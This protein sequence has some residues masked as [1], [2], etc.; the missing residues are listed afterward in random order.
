MKRYLLS[1]LFLVL[2]SAV[3]A[4]E[5]VYTPTPKAPENDAANQMPDAVISWYA[6]T[7]S[8]NLQYQLQVD[9]T[10]LFNSPLKI[11]TTQLLV[12]GYKTR[13]LLFNQ[14]YYW[15]VRAIDGETSAWSEAWSFTVFNTV[16][17]KNP[18]ANAAS[19]DP[20]VSIEWASTITT[21]KKPITGITY[22]NYQIDTDTNFNSPNLLQGTTTP[23]VLKASTVNLL[24]G[25][26]YYWRVRAGHAK[27]NSSY[28][29][30]RNFTII[31]KPTLSTPANNATKVFLDVILKWKEIKGLLAYGY[32]IAKDEAFTNMVESSDIDTNLVG[33]TNLMFGEK[34]YWRAR[35]RHIKDTSSWSDPFAFTTINT[36][37]LKSPTDGQTNVPLSPML[38]WTKQTGIVNYEFWLDSLSSFE[39]PLIKFKPEAN[40]IQ[41]QISRD[42]KPQRTY[43]W[44]MRAYSDGGITADTTAWSPVWSF[45]TAGPAG[46][47]DKDISSFTIYPNPSKGK[48]FVTVN[49]GKTASAQFEVIDFLGKT[50]LSKSVDLVAG[51]NKKEIILENIN[52]GIYVVR[53][54]MDDTIVNQKIVIEK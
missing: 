39:N 19:Q 12:T 14:K 22:Y 2:I 54:K 16:E 53:L 1:F 50:L 37:D 30:S 42:L 44:K 15:R 51:Q 27:G 24:F 3:F 8:L 20:N 31:A 26:I 52:N 23:E 34:Y 11:D 25:Q 21:S 33:A 10:M 9:T 41:Y 36:V 7:G 18:A 38:Q 46:I 4:Q 43:Y 17:L 40:D 49:S 35:G 47:Q 28:C 32:D 6:I 5:R 13:E 45:V 48:I 29:P